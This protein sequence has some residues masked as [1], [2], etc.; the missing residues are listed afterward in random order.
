MFAL[1]KNNVYKNTFNWLYLRDDIL[2]DNL[3]QQMWLHQLHQKAYLLYTNQI[4][5]FDFIV[6]DIIM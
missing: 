5:N 1:M 6:G 3:Q 2:R 4:D